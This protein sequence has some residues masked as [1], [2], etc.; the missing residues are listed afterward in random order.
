MSLTR[1]IKYVRKR[2]RSTTQQNVEKRA[3][4]A[5][6]NSLGVNLVPKTIRTDTYTIAVDGCFISKRNVV[7]AE[8]WAH[9]GA[10][11]GAQLK[12]I[13]ADILK[14]ALVKALPP[15]EFRG[16]KISTYA[17]FIDEIAASILKGKKWMAAAA[18][19]FEVVPK[20]VPLPISVSKCVKRSQRNQDLTKNGK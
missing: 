11:K 15:S 17:L 9:V 2:S 18:M 8:C 6:G 13:Q 19:H 1:T 7:L 10:T 16:K 14:F 4:A 5:F 12:K 20:I 3:I